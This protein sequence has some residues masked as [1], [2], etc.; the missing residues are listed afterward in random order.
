MSKPINLRRAVKKGKP[1]DFDKWVS[2]QLIRAD[3]AHYFYPIGNYKPLIG[4]YHKR[5]D[6]SG[7][8]RKCRKC[9]DEK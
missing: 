5:E 9:G 8:V 7:L 6:P 2:E 1:S 3:C 4:Q